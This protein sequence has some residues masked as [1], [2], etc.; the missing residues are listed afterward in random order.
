[1]SAIVENFPRTLVIIP[2]L[3]ESES[4]AHVIGLIRQH[5]P[6]ADIAVINDGSSDDTGAI[7]ES[8]GAF[9]LHMPHNVGIGAA[10]QTGF[11]FAQ[12]RGYAVTVQ[13]D[14]DGQHDPRE[15]PLLVSELVTSGADLVIGS[16]YIEDRGYIT[17]MA[18]R[19]GIVLLARAISLITRQHFTDPTSGFRASNARTIRLCARIYPHDYPEPEAVVLLHRAGLRVL[20]IPVTMNPRYGG[21]SSITPIK[22]GMYMFKVFLAIGVGLLRPPPHADD[23]EV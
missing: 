14:G 21:K 12:R 20:E 7:A 1:M 18:R 17:P 15:I 22:S 6:W 10:V 5:A 9:V 19:I 8:C 23:R 4:I 3:N 2:A 16:R 11:L 13:N